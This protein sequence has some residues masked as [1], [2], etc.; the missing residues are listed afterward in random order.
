Q[1][2]APWQKRLFLQRGRRLQRPSVPELTLAVAV[3]LSTAMLRLLSKIPSLPRAGPSQCRACRLPSPVWWPTGSPKGKPRGARWP[4]SDGERRSA[5]PCPRIREI[6]SPRRSPG[7]ETD[8]SVSPKP[9]A[10]LAPTRSAAL[11]RVAHDS[12][13]ETP[14]FYQAGS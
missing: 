12:R 11:P 13:D 5:G 2:F 8:R 3:A 1:H 10:V 14:L 6:R 7:T 9:A 4:A